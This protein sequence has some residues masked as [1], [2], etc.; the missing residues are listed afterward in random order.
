MR[1]SKWVVCT[2]P[3]GMHSCYQLQQS[4]GQGN[5]FT[6]VCDSVHR[7]RC[8]PRR[9]PQEGGTPLTRRHPPRR[10]P[11]CQGDPPKEAPQRRRL[12]QEGGPLPQEGGTP[13]EGDPPQE[14][15]SGIRSMSGRYASYWNAFLFEH[16]FPH[17]TNI[18][19]SQPAG[20]QHQGFCTRVTV[21]ALGH[22][23]WVRDAIIVLLTTEEGFE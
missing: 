12:P 2:H 3:T 17:A 19:K 9:P 16:D 20:F 8:L 1:Y 18:T 22:I 15:D 13:Q 11:P 4:C 10:R 23:L 14:A 5:V 6:A 7:G 21:R